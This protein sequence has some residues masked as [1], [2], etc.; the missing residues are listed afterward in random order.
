MGVVS[1]MYLYFYPSV[2]SPLSV[3]SLALVSSTFASLTFV[4]LP[5]MDYIY[6][7]LTLLRMSFLPKHLKKIKVISSEFRPLA[8][9]AP[10]PPT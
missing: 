10:L 1:L 3:V 2:F 8:A 9:L 5:K 4:S 7:L 6:L